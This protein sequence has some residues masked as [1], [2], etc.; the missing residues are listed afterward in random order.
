MLIKKLNLSVTKKSLIYRERGNVE[1]LS[2]AV[3]FL[4]MH[5]FVKN[6]L[7]G[8]VCFFWLSSNKYSL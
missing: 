7:L 1:R 2:F 4:I 5:V 8:H 3:S 6:I